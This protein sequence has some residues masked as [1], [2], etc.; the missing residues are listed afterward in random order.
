MSSPMAFAAF[1]LKIRRNFCSD[2]FFWNRREQIIALA[3]QHAIPT[4]YGTAGRDVAGG[5]LGAAELR[6]SPRDVSV[7]LW[8]MYAGIAK[9]WQGADAEA[10]A[11]LR[12]CIETN[13]T[14]ALGHFYLAA[15]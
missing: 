2:P 11:W 6:V 5:R 8:M 4:I 3:A 12:R 9:L 1:R 7:H 13:R 10:V 14:N 15:A